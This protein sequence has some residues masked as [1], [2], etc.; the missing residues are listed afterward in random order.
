MY[1]DTGAAPELVQFLPSGISPEGLVAIPSR[2]LLATANEV[3]LREDGGVGSHV[4]VY[5]QQDAPAAYP[6]ITSQGS[7]SLIGWGALSGLAADPDNAG[8]LYAIN[9]SFYG[10]QPRIFTIDATQTPARIIS[11]LVTPVPSPQPAAI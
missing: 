9:D 6:Q 8:M 3:D 2:N 11:A 10:Y 7:D 1:K 4:M 5:E